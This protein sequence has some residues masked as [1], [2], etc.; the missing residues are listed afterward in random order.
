MHVF[1]KCLHFLFAGILPQV[2]R[3][4]IYHIDALPPCVHIPLPSPSPMASSLQHTLQRVLL[5]LQLL[6]TAIVCV[7]PRAITCTIIPGQEL[8]RLLLQLRRERMDLVARICNSSTLEARAGFL[9]IAG[10][11]DN[12]ASIQARPCFREENPNRRRSRDGCTLAV[13]QAFTGVCC[14]QHST[15]CQGTSEGFESGVGR[16]EG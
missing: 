12:S 13:P 11:P 15:H 9:R 5:S 8:G 1:S 6:L 4:Q 2:F 3:S 16:G 10:Q 14:P 7:R